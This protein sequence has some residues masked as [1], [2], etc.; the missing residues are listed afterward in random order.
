MHKPAWDLGA[1]CPLCLEQGLLQVT[2]QT[3]PYQS[4]FPNHS[5]KIATPFPSAPYLS[6]ELYA[7]F[8][9]TTL[10]SNCHFIYFSYLFIV[11]LS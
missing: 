11:C 3:P 9:S 1:C 10:I 7:L 6:S 2:A 8:F 4:A 5:I